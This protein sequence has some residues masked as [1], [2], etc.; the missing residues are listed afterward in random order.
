MKIDLIA[1]ELRAIR[2]RLNSQS[3]QRRKQDQQSQDVAY[4][5]SLTERLLKQIR[6]DPQTWGQA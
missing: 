2:K 6:D 4:L 1:Q 5:L 3:P